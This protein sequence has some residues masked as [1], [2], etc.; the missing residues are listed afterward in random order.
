MASTLTS[1]LLAKLNNLQAEFEALSAKTRQLE[2]RFESKTPELKGPDPFSGERNQVLDFILQCELKFTGEP[3]RFPTESSK[4]L[5]AASHLRGPALQWFQP[6]FSRWRLRLVP[7]LPSF[8][9]FKGSITST[10]GDQLI[11]Q[12]NTYTRE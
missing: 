2:L 7:E 4:V 5:Y 1:Q 8:P 10:F 12:T 6:I 11:D 3:H 9:S